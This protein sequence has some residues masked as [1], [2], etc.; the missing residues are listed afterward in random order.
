MNITNYYWCKIGAL[1]LFF[2]LAACNVQAMRCSGNIISEGDNAARVLDLCGLPTQ[3]NFST[4]V[5][6]NKDRD[7][8]DYYVHFN[9]SGFVDSISFNRGS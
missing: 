7:G 8:M 3:N 1:I 4:M 9:A 5:Y 6:K 2:V